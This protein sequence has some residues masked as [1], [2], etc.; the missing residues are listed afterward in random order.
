MVKATNNNLKCDLTVI[1]ISNYNRKNPYL[2]PI[3]PS[4]NLP[5]KGSQFIS[6]SLSFRGTN[7]SVGRGTETQFQVFGSPYFEA[8]KYTYQFIPKPN[9]GANP[10]AQ[11]TNMLWKI[12]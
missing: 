1:P 11:R 5:I 9:F 4:P 12:S 3:R 10:Q 8:Q 6:K 7:V 2:L